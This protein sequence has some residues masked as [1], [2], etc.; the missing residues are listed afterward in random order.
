[1]KFDGT[2][3]YAKTIAYKKLQLLKLSRLSI[4]QIYE[5]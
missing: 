3:S 2:K 5:I 1:M 4:L